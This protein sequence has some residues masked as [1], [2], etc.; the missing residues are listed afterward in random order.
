MK[1]G[2][3]NFGQTEAL[4][5]K[6]GGVEGMKKVLS[7]E[8][9]VGPP[10]KVTSVK[11][12]A[13]RSASTKVLA[14]L[15]E[16]V[17]EPSNLPAVEHFVA[18]DKWV[19]DRN[20]ELSIIYLSPNIQKNFLDV[21]EEN[22]PVVSLKQRKLLKSA[23]NRPIIDAHG[24]EEKAKVAF[25]HVFEFLKTADRNRCFIFYVADAKGCVWA[26]TANWN[27]GS[28][29]VGASSVSDPRKWSAGNHVVSR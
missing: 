23:V 15:L 10:S 20:G 9:I 14:T 7:G 17:G 22:V 25:A 24:G 28:W 19:V 29:Y 13:L 5:N 3:V 6:I 4:L 8:W 2:E 11:E 1:Y 21:V 27:G 26:V 16:E 12:S 18:R